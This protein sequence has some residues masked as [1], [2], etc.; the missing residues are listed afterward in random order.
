ML[1]AAATIAFSSKFC[2]IPPPAAG[3]AAGTAPGGSDG[4]GDA[5]LSLA[6]VYQ[7]H[8]PFSIFQVV[9]E[10]TVIGISSPTSIAIFDIVAVTV[11]LVK[12]P[13]SLTSST[14]KLSNCAFP[15]LK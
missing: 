5:N 11:A 10:C 12:S 4:P 7:T 9:V 13:S 6:S 15:E 14:L 1:C 8:L 2:G 3:V